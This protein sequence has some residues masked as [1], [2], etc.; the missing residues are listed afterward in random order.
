MP[1]RD[2]YEY[3]I[4]AAV[5]SSRRQNLHDDL[6]KLKRDAEKFKESGLDANSEDGQKFME[7]F[8]DMKKRLGLERDVPLGRGFLGTIISLFKRSE[9]D[10]DREIANELEK[11]MNESVGE[12]HLPDSLM[13]NADRYQKPSLDRGMELD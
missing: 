13:K 6:E 3:Q 10:K 8:K 5:P 9:Q 12:Y 2:E 1:I 4:E 7:N 11:V